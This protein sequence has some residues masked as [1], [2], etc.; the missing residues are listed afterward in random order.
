MSE[1]QVWK[2][3]DLER[4]LKGLVFLNEKSTRKDLHLEGGIAVLRELLSE[5]AEPRMRSAQTISKDWVDD[6]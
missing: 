1:K 4:R 5:P 2:R 3:K 6:H